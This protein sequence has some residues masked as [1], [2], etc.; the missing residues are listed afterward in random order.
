M[1][2]GVLY[3]NDGD[4]VESCSALVEHMDGRLEIVEWHS[5]KGF[6]KDAATDPTDAADAAFHTRFP[7]IFQA[8][9]KIPLPLGYALFRHFHRPSSGVMV[10]TV[11]VLQLLQTRGFKNL[12][13]WTHGVDLSLF[14][15]RDTAETCKQLGPCNGPAFL[16]VGRVSY[17]KNIEAFLE[18]ALAGTKVV[19]GVG[20]REAS[21]KARFPHVRW[22][23]LLERSELQE[24]YAA[25]DVF[26]F[27][28]RSE[29]FGLVMLEA[30]ACGTPVAAYPVNGPLEV[31]AA[32]DGVRGG[33]L[34]NDLQQACLESLKI[35]RSQARQRA[36]DF[37]WSHAAALFESHLV[38]ARA[39]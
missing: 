22:L 28:S 16:Y 17:E 31:L 15:Y 35:P 24:V 30:M 11:G 12:K 21:L 19:C 7:E 39:D 23:G 3:C 10:P 14:E 1:I 20:P 9:L 6:A 13:A 26:V 18:L 32:Q 33:V 29:T 27:P 5:A 36:L 4:W 34:H 37:S 25:A 38:K 2:D 8:A